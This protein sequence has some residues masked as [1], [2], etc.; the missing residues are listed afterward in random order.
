MNQTI[1]NSFISIFHFRSEIAQKYPNKFIHL[2]HSRIYVLNTLFNLPETYLLACLI[3]Y[4]GN[5]PQYER[6]V[7]KNDLL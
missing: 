5:S 4:F 1:H 7:M 3:D 6:Y 2:D